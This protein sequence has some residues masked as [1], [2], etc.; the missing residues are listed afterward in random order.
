MKKEKDEE[1]GKFIL[2]FFGNA[3][4]IESLTF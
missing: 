1:Q 4:T 3:T 2:I